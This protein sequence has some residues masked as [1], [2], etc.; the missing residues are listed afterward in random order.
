MWKDPR[1]HLTL[2]TDASNREQLQRVRVPEELDIIIDDGSH[3]FGDQ[4]ATLHTLWPR[5]RPGGFYIVEDMLVGAL[6]WS[7]EHAAHVM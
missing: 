4:E 2:E 5:L 6:P 1:V 3:K 7:A